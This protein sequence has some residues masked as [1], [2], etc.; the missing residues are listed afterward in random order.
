[1]ATRV[2]A[3]ITCVMQIDLP[4]RKLF[5]FPTIAELA[6]E[7]ENRRSIGQITSG[8]ALTRVDRD[9]TNR[10]PL[11]FA[12]QRLWFL[13]QLEGQLTA[14][15][16]PYAWRLQGP[17]DVEALRRALEEVMRRH[18]PLRTTF[19]IIDEEPVQIIR[20]SERFDLQI[21]DLS[22]FESQQ[23][24]DHVARRCGE[25]ALRPFDLKGDRMLRG[26]LL[27]LSENEHI[28]LLTMHHIASDGWSVEL[29]FR[30]LSKLYEAFKAAKPSPLAALP[31]QYV[32]YVFLQRTELEGQ[33]LQQLLQYWRGQLAGISVLELPTDRPRPTM[34][35][36]L[37]GQHS[38]ELPKS[39][40]T[41]LKTLSQ[42]A[43]VTLHMTLLAAFKTLLSRYSGQTDI[44]IGVPVAGRN[45]SE[46]E[47]L[48][49]FFV[50]TLVNR[51]DMS[52]EPT[53]LEVL[54][55]VRES[56]LSAYDHQDLPF[57]RLVE[58]LRPE[59]LLGRSPLVQVLFQLLNFS[60]GGLALRDLEVSLLPSP[61]QRVRFDLELHLWQKPKNLCGTLVYSKD[62]F[63][64]STIDRMSQHFVTLLEGIVSVPDQR[65]R[66]LPLLT[67]AERHQL[68]V[69]W[70][71]TNVEYPRD[72][73][74]HQ[75]FEEQVER[76]PDS[77]AVVF[78]EQELT[79]RQLNERA[80][81]L[82]HQLIGMGVGPETLVGLCLERSAQLV[83]G[84]LGIMK[85]GGAYVP[86]DADL[87]KQRLEF[88]MRDSMV[89]FLVT[90]H[91]LKGRIP[92]EGIPVVCIDRELPILQVDKRENPS[93]HVCAENLAYVMYTSG[94]TGQPKGVAIRHTSIARLVFGNNYTSFGPDR[95]FLQ[96]ATPSFDASTFEL[97]GPLLHGAK[98]VV[99]QV[100]LP[101][102]RKLADLLQRN[103]VTT[104]WLTATLFNQLVD[105]TPQA[106]AG[107]KEILSG[108]EALSVPHIR[109]AQAALGPDVQF[110]NG[111]G[112]TESTTFA[113]CYRI[114]SNIALDCDSIPIGRPI[115]NTQVYVLDAQRQLVPI[116]VP[117]ELYIGGA[118]LARGY[119]NRPEL[120]TEK[121]VLNPFSKDD[122][123][124]LYRTGDLC[125]W[126]A[127]GNLEFLGRLDDQIKLRGF[128]IEP[129]EIESVL[130]EHSDI[131]Q[132]TV[133]LRKDRTGDERLVA[134]YVPK[135]GKSLDSFVLRIHLRDKLPDYM[136][137]AAFVELEAIPLTPSGKIDRQAL[138]TP[139]DSRPQLETKYVAP[140]TPIEKQLASIWA[141]VLGIENIGI[142]DNFFALG[143]HSLMAVRL[144]T[145][146]ESTFARRIPLAMLFQ[147]GTVHHLAG[148]LAES[149]PETDPVSLVKIKP[150]GEGRAVY[151][152]PSINGELLFSKS[153]IE[154]MGI[155]FPVFGLQ[156]A[157][158]PKNLEHFR[159]FRTMAT[160]Y[161]S[162]LRAFQ[163][164]GPYALVG[165]SFGGFLA[166]EVA[167]QLREM[168]ET[169]DLL[170]VIDTGPGQR[171]LRLSAYERLRGLLRNLS[172]FPRYLREV[173]RNFSTSRLN[174]SVGRKLRYQLRRLASGQQYKVEVYDV[175]DANQ[176]KTQNI[177]LMRTVFAALQ[178]YI[179]SRCSVKLSLFRAKTRPLKGDSSRD[180]GWSRFVD[181][182]DVCS[183]NGTHDTILQPPNVN[184][185]AKQLT[186]RLDRI[187]R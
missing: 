77:I 14:Y 165:F 12:Q 147:H 69:E 171:G 19:A 10:L 131:T 20:P 101:D 119:W 156:P 54:S 33:R 31:V 140:S 76:T 186:E 107:V 41:R 151:L 134:Y 127:D 122:Q 86:L 136:I 40:V 55:R 174:R 124:R 4:L 9:Q 112:P 62:L 133:I 100:G 8:T 25:E 108:G 52:G 83:I 74:V 117:G 71:D 49:G 88:M 50:N 106:L 102:F 128:R 18:E 11:S 176:V 146:I 75:L 184:E 56:S 32:D 17:L 27:L 84:I 95:V 80:N 162:A 161:V 85:A 172:N 57:E 167:Y 170:A 129:G 36:H 155:H 98:L 114:P 130:N 105:H 81:Q 68:L 35:T 64:P 135:E 38:F 87:P 92:L 45:R 145:R 173:L 72:K 177:E 139:D 182:L 160:L 46:L 2:N 141:D 104:L 58:E 181:D 5:E 30:K 138:P 61:R 185:L 70:N 26:S 187:S 158:S 111:Y 103:R 110:I 44:A 13:E 23:Q 149:R 96:L 94:S 99:A 175:L 148:L 24:N 7:I 113:T 150:K 125:R 51:T 73:C 116:G 179:P 1:M 47:N 89:K 90:Q 163:P 43:G 166:Y 144:F 65:I 180:L 154:E 164:N 159:D 152:M 178:D 97:W 37:G 34:T 142:H 29:L 3:R 59:R 91:Q 28:L 169:V 78:Q 123:E 16:M 22:G 168:G 93:I 53:F 42:T 120:T 63:D 60:E 48:I 39:L 109:K 126:R 143:G 82:A 121:F 137:P 132:A 183:I 115:A 153:M 157:L 15:N 66:E 6:A 118:G 21:E 79:Y 67:A